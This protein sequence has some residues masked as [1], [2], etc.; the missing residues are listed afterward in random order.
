MIFPVNS[1]SDWEAEVKKLEEVIK[2]CSQQP[3]LAASFSSLYSSTYF[4]SSI[5]AFF[6]LF[7]FSIDSVV[8]SSSLPRLPPLAASLP[9]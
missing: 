1:L 9:R 8:T 7:S 3:P 6:A 5:F 2:T 4:S